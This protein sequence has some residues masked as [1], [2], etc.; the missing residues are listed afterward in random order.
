MTERKPPHLELEGLGDFDLSDLAQSFD[1]D[2]KLDELPD[3]P[4]LDPPDLELFERGNLALEGPGD[5]AL[6]GPADLADTADPPLTHVTNIRGFPGN[7]Q[8]RRPDDTVEG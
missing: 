6:E 5:L 1:F 2:V 4:P 3:F 7:G 8:S